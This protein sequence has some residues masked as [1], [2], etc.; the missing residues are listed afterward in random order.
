MSNLQE[1]KSIPRDTKVQR[2]DPQ[3]LDHGIVSGQPIAK[4][5]SEPIDIHQYRERHGYYASGSS[6]IDEMHPYELYD[7]ETL[8]QLAA[9]G[10]GLAQLV[11]GDKVVVMNP[12]RADSLYWQSV[13]NGQTAAL[14]NI[15]ASNMVLVPGATDFGFHFVDGDGE[16]STDYARILGYYAAVE[17]LGDFIATDILRSHIEESEFS[18]STMSIIR[19][20]EAGLELADRIKD[21][22][23]DKWGEVILEEPLI[24][25]FDPPLSVCG[26]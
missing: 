26:K 4:G 25:S 3:D 18:G 9:N 13:V 23:R 7:L 1:L 19:I 22:R 15:A 11:L 20:C 5:D 10:D 12:D 16:I 21:E 6:S 2:P 14:V 8:E 24:I 17:D